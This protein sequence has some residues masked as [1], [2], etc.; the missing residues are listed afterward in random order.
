MKSW[1]IRWRITAWGALVMALALTAFALGVAWHLYTESVGDLDRDLRK[2]GVRLLKA[3]SHRPLPLADD[4]VAEEVALAAPVRI[5]FRVS[6]SA[7]GI[8]YESRAFPSLTEPAREENHPWTVIVDGVDFRGADFYGD[9]LWVRGVV[10]MKEV[11]EV[12]ED[13]LLSYAFALPASLLIISFGGFWLSKRAMLPVARI[14]STA[15]RITARS[16]SERLPVP[17]ARDEIAKLTDVLNRMIDRLER[18]FHQARRFTADASHQI[19][20]PLTIMRAEIE[21]I[22]RQGTRH[23]AAL[24]GVLEEIAG[25]ST[26]TDRLLLL[27]RGDADQLELRREQ[28]DLSALLGELAEDFS[29]LGEEQRIAVSVAVPE[30]VRLQGDASLLRQLFVNLL[31]NALKYNRPDGTVSLTATAQEGM[32]EVSIVNTGRQIAP[33]EQRR[34]FQPFDR[35]GAAGDGTRGTGLGLNIAQELARVHGG[36][37]RLVRSG[38]GETEFRV[39]LPATDR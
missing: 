23:E 26:M 28:V 3:V 30:G 15:E 10:E 20:T 17:E 33:E 35:G 18:S 34:I 12:W 39:D 22:L 16:L 8:I 32:I 21:G 9:G 4:R 25:L 11:D 13:L 37:V 38:A 27:A 29:A 1:T 24:I 5:L 36:S 14:A 7:H 2:S 31:E 19:K 6:D